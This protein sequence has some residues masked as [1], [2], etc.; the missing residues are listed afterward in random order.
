MTAVEPNTS[1]TTEQVILSLIGTWM[2]TTER[3][4]PA[5]QGFSL[6]DSDKVTS[7]NMET[8]K[9]THWEQ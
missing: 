2:Q 3:M 1:D 6:M 5:E 4:E 7:V 9:Y 8:L